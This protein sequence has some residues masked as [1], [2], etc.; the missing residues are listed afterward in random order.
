[1]GCGFGKR[2]I[3]DSLKKAVWITVTSQRWIVT[4]E[5]SGL[6]TRIAT[7]SGSLCEP[8]NC[9]SRT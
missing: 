1:M 9:V 4:A 7:E 2:I 6:L 8:L 3:A 5:Q